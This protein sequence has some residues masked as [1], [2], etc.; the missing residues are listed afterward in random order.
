M[1]HMSSHPAKQH[2]DIRQ[3]KKRSVIF[4]VIV[5][6]IAVH[7]LGLGVFG[8]IKIVET[9]ATPPDFEAPPVEAVRPPPPPPP[10]PPPTI[11]RA[12]RS[13]PRPQ[14]LVAQN[15]QN[16]NVPA[17]VLQDAELSVGGGRGFGGGIGQLGS[18]VVESIRL[19]SFGFDRAMEGTLEGTL[20]D[21]KRSADQEPLKT[22]GGPSRYVGEILTKFTR[23][24]S[25]SHLDKYYKPDVRLYGASFIIPNTQASE[26]PRAFQAEGMVDPKM[27][28]VAY[29]GSYRPTESGRFRL[30]GRGD[31]VLIVRINGRIVMDASWYGPPSIY[32]NWKQS[33]V[34]KRK[35][36]EKKNPHTLYRKSRDAM[37]TSIR[38]APIVSLSK[39]APSSPSAGVLTNLLKPITW[40]PSAGLGHG[41]TSPSAGPTLHGLEGTARFRSAIVITSSPSA[42]PLL[43]GHGSAGSKSSIGRLC[44][45]TTWCS[46]PWAQKPLPPA[47]GSSSA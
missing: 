27:L 28:A 26:A 43:T 19:S 33:Q 10:P 21:F 39:A 38:P 35:Q 24:F 1:G 18:T 7:L 32:T 22:S 5:L 47:S 42:T 25:R 13:M 12:Q 14:P 2:T 16:M 40:A 37:F 45:V 9:I 31:N 34:A 30:S 8:V 15:P 17:I 46:R 36:E 41:S 29:K 23:S 20:Y 44:M 6:S 4:I 11:K 3:G